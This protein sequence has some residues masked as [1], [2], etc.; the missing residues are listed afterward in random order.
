MYFL[1]R[2]NAF[3]SFFVHIRPLYRYL[4][5][6][7]FAAMIGYGWFYGVY[8]NIAIISAHY[9]NDIVRMQQNHTEAKKAAQEKEKVQRS[10]ASLK[11]SLNTYMADGE[12]PHDRLQNILDT[13][14]ERAMMDGLDFNACTI[15]KEIEKNGYMQQIVA[16]ELSGSFDTILLFCDALASLPILLEWEHSELIHKQAHYFSLRCTF[17]LTALL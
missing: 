9:Q 15:E 14:L 16:C 17:L 3:Y 12:T 1:P 7:L 10:I 13:I 11:E 5:T 2:N 8:C 4:V 6:L